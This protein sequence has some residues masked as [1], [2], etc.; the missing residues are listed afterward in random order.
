MTRIILSYDKKNLTSDS[1][2][3][4]D[5]NIGGWKDPQHCIPFSLVPVAIHLK[6]HN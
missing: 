4:N 5:L 6:Y 1:I 3:W 2:L